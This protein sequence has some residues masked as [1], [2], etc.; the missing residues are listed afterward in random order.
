MRENTAHS[1]PWINFM[2]SNSVSSSF[3]LKLFLRIWSFPIH[4]AK[5]IYSWW[6]CLSSLVLS[7]SFSKVIMTEL[8]KWH[9][10]HLFL[11]N[12]I[13]I[14]CV[15]ARVLQ[16]YDIKL[17]PFLNSPHSIPPALKFYFDLKM[18]VLE[19]EEEVKKSSSECF[20]R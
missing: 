5:R 19:V 18:C 16:F 15:I 3:I 13:K 11:Q 4:G 7:C 9:I 10:L 12:F 6:C 14:F 20:Q 1:M 8:W 17:Y 2:I